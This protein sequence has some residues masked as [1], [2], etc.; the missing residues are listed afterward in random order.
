MR[1][2]RGADRPSCLAMNPRNREASA[3]RRVELLAAFDA[4]PEDD[5]ADLLELVE[6]WASTGFI[7]PDKREA[8]RLLNRL[9]VA[10]GWAPAPGHKLGCTAVNGHDPS[11]TGC[12][13]PLET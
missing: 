13:V 1:H 6:S 10:C 5:R 8:G 11:R 4:L 7:D 2:S 12:P 3:A 9:Y